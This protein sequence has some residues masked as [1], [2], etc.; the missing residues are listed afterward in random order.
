MIALQYVNFDGNILLK[1][2]T[3]NNYGEKKNP[4]SAIV[5]DD[6]DDDEGDKT[7]GQVVPALSDDENEDA[8]R[9][10]GNDGE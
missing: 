7:T 3:F 6:D 1:D 4:F 10:S 8:A 9:Q 5:S 2:S